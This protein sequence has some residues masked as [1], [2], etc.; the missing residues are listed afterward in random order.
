MYYLSINMFKLVLSKLVNQEFFNL[1]TWNY[2][3]LYNLFYTMV[4]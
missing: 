4:T 2:T 3:S 1:L